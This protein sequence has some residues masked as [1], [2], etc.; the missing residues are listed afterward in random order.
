MK[1]PF[2]FGI[3]ALAATASI[4]MAGGDEEKKKNEASKNAATL[5]R[6]APQDTKS[7]I[8][9]EGGAGKGITFDMGDDFSLKIG[10]RVQVLWNYQSNEAASAAPGANTSAQDI[11]SFRVRRARTTFGGHLYNKDITYF[12]QNEWTT[13]GA[14]TGNLLDA[15]LNWNF[16]KGEGEGKDSIA[17]RLGAQKTRFGREQTGTSSKL[18]FVDRSVVSQVFS[19]NRQIGVLLNGNHMEKKL[20]WNFGVFNGDPAGAATRLAE[21]GVNPQNVDQEVNFV[22][23]VRLDPKGDMGDEGYEQ[24]DLREGEARQQFA[25][26]VGA[27]VFVGNGRTTVGGV[28]TDVE[29]TSININAAMKYNGFHAL[30]D[31]FIRSDDRDASGAVPSA[32]SDTTGFQIGGSYTM[33]AKEKGASQWAF[34]ARFGLIDADATTAGGVSV[35]HVAFP[36]AGT[37]GLTPVWLNGGK[38]TEIEAMVSNYYKKHNLKTQLGYRHQTIDPDN[39]SEADNDILEILFTFTF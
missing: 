26:S 23:G 28:T 4:A 27:G 34:G 13:N 37:G 24:G 35:G 12:V 33:E 3:A 25:Y 38:V 16:W 1:N 39:G 8:K 7:A 31:V 14:N 9:V 32:E 30:G 18:E 22:A 11:N 2:G 19:G 36:I 10:N 6:L 15:W 29:T 5:E 21:S 20:H 17:L